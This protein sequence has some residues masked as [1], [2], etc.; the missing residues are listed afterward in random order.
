MHV[1][2]YVCMHARMQAYIYVCI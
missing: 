2:I 1:C